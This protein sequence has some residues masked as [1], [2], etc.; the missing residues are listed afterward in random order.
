MT[1]EPGPLDDGKVVKVIDGGSDTRYCRNSGPLYMLERRYGPNSQYGYPANQGFI[2][3]TVHI[4]LFLCFRP[5][6]VNVVEASCKLQMT[7]ST[8]VSRYL[9]T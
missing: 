2:E 3:I 1:L 4:K 9:S 7:S 8:P 5:C 6:E